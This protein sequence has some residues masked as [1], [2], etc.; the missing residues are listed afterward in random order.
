MD[1]ITILECRQ[2]TS[3]KIASGDYETTLNRP[4]NIEQGDSIRLKSAFLDTKS[5]TSGKIF[6]PQTSL[7]IAGHQYITNFYNPPNNPAY[8]RMYANATTT[9]PDPD[10]L[11]GDRFVLSKETAPT[12]SATLS[13]SLQADGTSF[14][15]ASSTGFPP[16]GGVVFIGNEE[17]LYDNITG[18]T[19]NNLTRGFNNTTPAAYGVGTKVNG[20]IPDAVKIISVGIKNTTTMPSSAVP[21]GKVFYNYTNLDGKVIQDAFTSFPPY[22]GGAKGTAT[23]T[24]VDINILAQKSAQVPFTITRVVAD[25]EPTMK[26]THD[27]PNTSS[28][29]E[30]VYEPVLLSA[31]VSIDEGFYDPT[32]LAKKITDKLSSS[33]LG[34]T[35]LSLLPN[36]ILSPFMSTGAQFK[37]EDGYIFANAKGKVI[38]MGNSFGND[39]TIAETNGVLAGTNQVA[40]EFDTDINKF[41]FKQLHMPIFDFGGG[42]NPIVGLFEGGPDSS[43]RTYFWASEAGGFLL[44]NITSS[45]P[46]FME[47]ILGFDNSIFAHYTMTPR[48]FTDTATRQFLIPTFDLKVGVNVTSQYLGL[49]AAVLKDPYTSSANPKPNPLVPILSDSPGSAPFQ[50]TSTD[51]VNIVASTSTINTSQSGYFLI[52]INTKFKTAF[53]GSNFFSRSIQGIVSRYYALNSYTSADES[54]GIAY[55]HTSPEPMMLTSL[56]VRIL[57]PS[58]QLSTDVG[59]DNTV[60]V[61]II[62]GSP[63]VSAKK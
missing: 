21:G 40:L 25:F 3:H 58:T 44:N 2:A 60:F 8:P 13:S 51:I 10:V 30:T 34:G 63:P 16:G 48:T 27:P 55:I 24:T 33:T 5:A 31:T 4:I 36:P 42:G 46:N 59:D 18:N 61:E 49:D 53:V 15:V 26:F 38:A 57:D 28:L 23:G 45:P 35:N 32:A 11:Q 7:T 9:P 50:S 39:P 22:D 56:R 19:F 12:G 17:I 14:T 20:T 43:N 1:Q 37:V 54:A 52:D 41:L 62:K 29:K 6:V 47:N